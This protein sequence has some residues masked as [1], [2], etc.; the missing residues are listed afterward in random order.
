[1]CV[2]VQVD[3]GPI[4]EGSYEGVRG[5]GLIIGSLR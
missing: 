1:M 5:G 2:C 4:N 3:H